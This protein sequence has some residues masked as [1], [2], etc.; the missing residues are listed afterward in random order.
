MRR[1]ICSVC[2]GLV[3]ETNCVQVFCSCDVHRRWD[4]GFC[5]DSTPRASTFG[6]HLPESGSARGASR[7][8]STPPPP[9]DSSSWQV[10]EHDGRTRDQSQG[11]CS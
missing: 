7:R 5:E 10:G 6:G 1:A 11:N 3:E 8:R 2:H 4:L 9:T